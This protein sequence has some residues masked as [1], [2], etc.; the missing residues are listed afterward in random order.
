M[1]TAVVS[2]GA[3]LRKTN[4]AEM[5][6][7]IADK[8]R[9]S[10]GSRAKHMSKSLRPLDTSGLSLAMTSLLRTLSNA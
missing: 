2:G 7:S 10:V 5:Q 9:G 1:F 4:S 8:I 3:M 6:E